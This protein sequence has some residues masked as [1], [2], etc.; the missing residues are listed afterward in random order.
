MWGFLVHLFWVVQ[1]KL[2]RP[3]F[4]ICPEGGFPRPVS[5]VEPQAAMPL[6]GGDARA[7]VGMPSAGI[8]GFLAPVYLTVGIFDVG[9]RVPPGNL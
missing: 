2:Y 6:V 8:E 3:L 9:A 5:A 1:G 4:V 7:V